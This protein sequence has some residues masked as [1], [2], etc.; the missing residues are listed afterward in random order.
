MH[1]LKDKYLSN[2][3]TKVY[4]VSIHYNW[5][6]ETI[7]MST[8]SIYFFFFLDK[9]ENPR[10]WKVRGGSILSAAMLFTYSNRQIFQTE[11]L[12]RKTV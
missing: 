8:H 4:A 1:S 12:L 2:F 5:R 3:S 7:L 6:A 9:S 10:L 11:D